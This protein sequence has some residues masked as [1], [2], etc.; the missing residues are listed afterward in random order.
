MTRNWDLKNKTALVTGTTELAEGVR[1]ALAA[2]G[3]ILVDTVS[4]A[5]DVLVTVPDTLHDRNA[6]PLDIDGDT[7]AGAMDALF[8]A[9]R[10]ATHAVLP[11]MTE[12]EFGRIVHV[13]GSLEPRRFNA[14]FAAWGAMGAWSKSLTRAIGKSGPTMNLIQAGLLP[15]DAP[16]IDAE[17]ELKQIPAGRYCTAADIASL[18]VFLASPYA[19]Y[20]T[21][22][23]IP[24]DGGMRRYQ[25]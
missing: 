3:A 8:E 18:V 24:V 16:G 17:T 9:P 25:N 19:R 20:L 5:V 7:W 4:P 1:A 13:I 21:G 2:E 12:R 6:M 10:R 23:V 11:G 15:S 14:E 22:T